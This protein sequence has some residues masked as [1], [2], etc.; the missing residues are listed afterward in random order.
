MRGVEALCL[1]GVEETPIIRQTPG[2]CIIQLGPV[3]I[4]AAWL[5]S[6]IDSAAG[7]RLLVIVWRGNVAPKHAQHPERR[8]LLRDLPRPATAL[9]ED[10]LVASGSSEE[11]WAWRRETADEIHFSSAH[12]AA[13]CVERL[14]T[15]YG[16]EKKA[17]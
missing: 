13:S 10:A 9:W 17:A 5:R 12:L 4:T 15:A 7:G 3:A 6:T 8:A 16:I 1:G 11:T 14:H 2:H